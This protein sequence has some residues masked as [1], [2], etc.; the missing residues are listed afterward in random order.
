MQDLLRAQARLSWQILCAF[1]QKQCPPQGA[2][3][4]ESS[5]TEPPPVAASGRA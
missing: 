4:D 1:D 3:T 5:F 2:N